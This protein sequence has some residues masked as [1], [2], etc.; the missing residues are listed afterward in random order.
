MND[1]PVPASSPAARPES[2]GRGTLF[3][4]LA[5]AAGLVSNAVIHV[6]AARWLLTAD[7]GRF[8]TVLF[9]LSW[10]SAVVHCIILPGLRKIVSE[11]PARYPAALAFAGKWYSLATLGLFAALAVSP[12]LLARLFGDAE[13]APLFRI[14]SLQVPF[15]AVLAVGTALLAAMHRF[16]RASL[17]GLIVSACRAVAACALLALGFGAAGAVGALLAGAVVAAPLV[18]AFLRAELR[19]RPRV[20]YPPM[21]ARTAHW[22]GV[23][24][25][26]T[27]ALRTAATLDI[28]LVKALLPAGEAG[29]YAAAYALARFPSFIVGGLGTAIFPHMSAALGAGHATRAR[30]IAREAMRFVILLFGGVCFITAASAEGIVTLLFTARYAAASGCLV[31]VVWAVFLSGLMQ[32]CF[33]LIGAAD[34]PGLRMA[35][36]FVL[37]AVAA[38]GNALLV[39]RMGILG[40]AAASVATFGVGAAMAAGMA[41]RLVR[42]L[43]PWRTALRC[44]VAGG[45]VLALG[46]VW[47]AT[48]W[49]VVPKLAALAGV[50]AALLAALRELKRRD[51]RRLLDSFRAPRAA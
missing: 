31:V 8:V 23:S 15:M 21:A 37:V 40:A 4:S 26:T 25:P 32:C 20:P 50:Y 14:A 49:R 38:G 41:Y 16:A 45:A 27:V 24:L 22:T 29:L 33:G 13:L 48:G 35:A 12:S 2:V 34:R 51:V 30:D 17:V 39:P 6:L 9:A 18:V 28:W 42:V 7:Y 5:N 47:P 3:M 36:S 1:S 19:D 11:D 10:L 44:G 43:P 46:L